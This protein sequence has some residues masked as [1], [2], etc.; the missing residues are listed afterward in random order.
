MEA[1]SVGGYLIRNILNIRN[2]FPWEHQ[3]LVYKFIPELDIKDVVY[4]KVRKLAIQI[5]VKER[6]KIRLRG[7][8]KKTKWSS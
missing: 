4:L 1:K 3:A 6:R 5:A 7:R 8:Y 2:K